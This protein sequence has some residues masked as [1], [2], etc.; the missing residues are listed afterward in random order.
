[1]ENFVLQNLTN[2]NKLQ[3]SFILASLLNLIEYHKGL[4]DFVETYFLHARFGPYNN[5]LRVE[6]FQGLQ[7]VLAFQKELKIKNKIFFMIL[8]FL[9]NIPN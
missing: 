1:M 7:L 6:Y 4:N 9:T 2:D 5:S 8:D 3:L